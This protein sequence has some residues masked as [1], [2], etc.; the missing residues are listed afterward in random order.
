[1]ID[2]KARKIDK[3]F[4]AKVDELQNFQDAADIAKQQCESLLNIILQTHKDI[5]EEA[6]S[7]TDQKENITAYFHKIDMLNSELSEI[8]EQ[9]EE[10]KRTNEIINNVEENINRHKAEL[11]D[12][13]RNSQKIKDDIIDANEE[14]LND[15]KKTMVDNMEN[16]MSLLMTKIG[17][18]KS[19]LYAEN[20]EN[21]KALRETNDALR[22]EISSTKEMLQEMKNNT[23]DSITNNASW[24][25]DEIN[26]L[27]NTVIKI[28]DGYINEFVEK[29]NTIDQENQQKIDTWMNTVNEF[30][31]QIS[32]RID[33]GR[34]DIEQMFTD[35]SNKIDNKRTEII[36]KMD[37]LNQT[38][39]SSLDDKYQEI[40]NNVISF[41]ETTRDNV[42][43]SIIKTGEEVN[44]RNKVLAE[45]LKNMQGEAKMQFDTLD[46][47]IAG[48]QDY[49]KR[50]LENTNEKI[51]KAIDGFD[52]AITNIGSKSS[53]LEN[54]IFARVRDSLT[55]F[56]SDTQQQIDNIRTSF[57]D[58]IMTQN[59]ELSNISTT[60]NTMSDEVNRIQ[61]FYNASFEQIEAQTRVQIENAKKEISDYRD[62]ADVAGEQMKQYF[63]EQKT[64]CF[65]E[66]DQKIAKM[67]QDSA[68][69]NSEIEKKYDIMVGNI[70]NE[71][72]ETRNKISDRI[73]LIAQS[74]DNGD[75]DIET[76]MKLRQDEIFGQLNDKFTAIKDELTA[77]AEQN[78]EQTRNKLFNQDS[79][80]DSQIGEMNTKIESYKEEI[81]N[82]LNSIE[83]NAA[84]RIGELDANIGSKI[85]LLTTKSN[86]LEEQYKDSTNRIIAENERKLAEFT[87]SFENIESQLNNLQNEINNDIQS[88]I[89]AGKSS[90][91]SLM[92]EIEMQISANKSHLDE[93]NKNLFEEYSN[94][95]NNLKSNIRQ[96]ESEYNDRYFQK[97]SDIDRQ[98][99][100]K[101]QELQQCIDN[102]NET[103]SRY[104]GKTAESYKRI[105]EMQT[106]FESKVG[107]IE[108]QLSEITEQ[109]LNKRS[110][111]IE[112]LKYNYDEI[113]NK[114]IGIHDSIDQI[115]AENINKASVSINTTYSA[116]EAR[117]SGKI[118]DLT[119]SLDDITVRIS[120]LESSCTDSLNE[121]I[122]GITAQMNDITVKMNEM[123]NT[124][125]G[126]ITEYI[127]NSEAELNAAFQQ[128]L[129]D[130]AA[131]TDRIQNE[132]AADI[133]SFE[134]E[135]ERFKTQLANFDKHYSE[136]VAQKFSETDSTLE[137]KLNEMQSVFSG[138]IAGIKANYQIQT[139]QLTEEK[140]QQLGS[141]REE[142]DNL[143]NEKNSQLESFKS[144]FDS[145]NNDISLIKSRL[146]SEINSQIDRGNGLL[147]EAFEAGN[148]MIEANYAKLH[149]E[150]ERYVNTHKNELLNIRQKTAD[151]ESQIND[152]LRSRFENVDLRI[153]DQFGKWNN[154]YNNFIEELKNGIG[155]TEKDFRDRLTALQTSYIERN[156]QIVN[157]NFDRFNELRE[158]LDS[159]SED[160]NGIN[161]RF[162]FYLNQ[163]VEEVNTNFTEKL[164]AADRNVS[165]RLT[166]LDNNI[167]V[168]LENL[169]NNVSTKLVGW[170]NNVN[171]KLSSIDGQITQYV[172]SFKDNVDARFV[173]IDNDIND[174]VNQAYSKLD[175]QVAAIQNEVISKVESINE[176]CKQS[177]NAM[178]EENQ[179]HFF[180][181]ESRIKNI[182]QN[183]ETYR[184]QTGNRLNT[185]TN[186][187]IE[188]IKSAQ[189]DVNSI[190]DKIAHINEIIDDDFQKSYEQNKI[191]MQL[192]LDAH[193]NE[194]ESQY[195]Q[196]SD[197]TL[198][199]ISECREELRRM[200]DEFT[201]SFNSTKDTLDEI[202]SN[203][204]ESFTDKQN[205]LNNEILS[206]IN[207]YRNEFENIKTDMTVVLSSTKDELRNLI[208]SGKNELSDEY[209]KLQDETAAHIS[210]FRQELMS[211]RSGIADADSKLADYIA[212]KSTDIDRQ[213]SATFAEI[214]RTY[215]EQ[216]NELDGRLA[217]L[218]SEYS[219]KYQDL[220]NIY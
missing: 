167:T 64:H 141:F 177:T 77:Y 59:D 58:Q 180:E 113:Y 220:S 60:L 142:F 134:T 47:F 36:K 56:E 57:Q 125:D 18:L 199:Q 122:S 204:Q 107:D 203:A 10:I 198:S 169:D 210:E 15:L 100:D 117:T 179:K 212:N 208:A 158:K 149:E 72:Y 73:S 176:S 5:D 104:E 216:I 139:Q 65:D 160:M 78:I 12:I 28:K 79:Q 118:A 44:E 75:I 45:K 34:F 197:D 143:I 81:L 22:E 41:C 66:I 82:E 137:T 67:T 131:E 194:L 62:Y 6:S 27:N 76:Q 150:T 138:Q 190:N 175:S 147:A 8:S 37:E 162:D 196:I 26:K 52:K 71:L 108:K 106:A 74:L 55:E 92:N 157:R 171:D 84:T 112:S 110:M 152:K 83:S 120:Q 178:M 21:A 114:I 101:M 4:E 200:N 218:E 115:V 165:Q 13:R 161:S 43:D 50:Y 25:N 29:I 133:Q 69:K 202:I 35:F 16:E 23:I 24:A 87:S 214:N 89:D 80:I 17:E 136:Q 96:I 63:A 68:A 19:N 209:Q 105:D 103:N 91:T 155:N 124:L 148:A 191:D 188:K 3:N 151:L 116:L 94:E 163:K 144:E 7:L 153:D 130:F 211:V 170:D 132:A 186:E 187:Y 93:A 121:Q 164:D 219:D 168:R 182:V 129:N 146:D 46:N 86:S 135:L 97:Y 85:N 192:M 172:A 189:T 173:T 213:A 30:S 183:I 38:K 215:S 31:R 145:L 154:E 181:S 39:S 14:S 90:L 109:M 51:T 128:R 185:I 61:D 184:M 166:E 49:L 207:D 98:V 205:T 9:V 40:M 126:S 119:A 32:K 174:K 33:D 195:R 20:Q 95:I 217:S 48:K 123:R 201:E 11:E 1:M 140:N 111:E 159:I 156:D 70:E 206:K 2:E 53:L 42:N 88:K 127:N 193:K 99:I 54:E 102:F